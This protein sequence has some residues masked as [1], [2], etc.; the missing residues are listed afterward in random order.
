MYS[1]I[2]PKR[3]DSYWELLATAA[4]VE[5]SVE[6]TLR[7]LAG[8][9]IH[10]A[11]E[12]LAV[13]PSLIR[14][15]VESLAAW[16]PHALVDVIQDWLPPADIKG[17]PWWIAA[18]ETSLR[19]LKA[20]HAITR[21]IV[22]VP[23]LS[24]EVDLLWPHSREGRVAWRAVLKEAASPFIPF[25]HLRRLSLA[26]LEEQSLSKSDVEGAPPRLFRLLRGKAFRL[27]ASARAIVASMA[28][29]CLD[30]DPFDAAIIVEID[31]ELS[32]EDSEHLQMTL[33][34]RMSHVVDPR[35]LIPL[36]YVL[37]SNWCVP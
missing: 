6:K 24:E 29:G 36:F 14:E 10:Q 16:N 37:V 19:H 4:G 1:G 33:A 12:G 22:N 17:N 23:E 18:W 9:E 34:Q 21:S 7:G 30:C 3:H 20:L 15:R 35:S 25:N 27:D 31:K 11:H 28:L 26:E 13:A 2:I 32:P 8:R 5:E